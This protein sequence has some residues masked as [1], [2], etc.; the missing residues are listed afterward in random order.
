[1]ESPKSKVFAVLAS[2]VF[3]G[4]VGFEVHHDLL[5]D[6]PWPGYSVAGNYVVFLLV[7]PWLLGAASVW[8]PSDLAWLG[9]FP[10]ALAALAHGLGTVIGG[11]L[12]GAAFLVAAPVVILL[13]WW[14]RRPDPVDALAGG[15]TPEEVAFS[16]RR[17]EQHEREVARAR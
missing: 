2:V 1:M 12:G 7:P 13:C 14:A 16:R 6:E 10:G 4:M 17:R 8:I 5:R 15:P 9:I 3:L 11:A